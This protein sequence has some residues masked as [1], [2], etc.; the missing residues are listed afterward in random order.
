[1][2]RHEAI[3]TLLKDARAEKTSVTSYK[4]VRRALASLGLTEGAENA[5]LVW[6][7]YHQSADPSKPF[8]KFTEKADAK[9]KG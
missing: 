8:A 9:A 7:D 2:L 5:I 1:M 3:I 4:R 6:L